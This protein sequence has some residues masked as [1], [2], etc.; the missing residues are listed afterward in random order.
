MGAGLVARLEE[1]QVF[2][3]CLEAAR[4]R[5]SGNCGCDESAS[6]YGC[7]RSYRNQFAHHYLQRG[8]VMRYLGALLSQWR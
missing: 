8:P 5:V 2:K 6:C 7:L 1:E 4:K 3:A